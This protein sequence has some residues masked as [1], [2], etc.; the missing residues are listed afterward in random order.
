MKS[1]AGVSPNVRCVLFQ[2]PERR[3]TIKH[4]LFPLRSTA[5]LAHAAKLIRASAG[6]GELPAI[7]LLSKHGLQADTAPHTALLEALSREAGLVSYEIARMLLP[8]AVKSTLEMANELADQQREQ[9]IEVQGRLR[10]LPESFTDPSSKDRMTALEA[11]LIL[12]A[13]ENEFHCSHV[14]SKKIELFNPLRKVVCY[15]DRTREPS[16]I[17]II[18]APWTDLKKLCAIEGLDVPSAERW[19]HSSNLRS[20]PRHHHRGK[21]QIPY[22]YSIICK[23]EDS[24]KR[25]L[26]A[27]T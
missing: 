11:R 8:E 26:P 2:P 14:T 24:F 18:V 23:S 16:V 1:G 12:V 25:L 17:A 13:D 20:F 10:T 7:Q 27:L 15:I 4:F 9:V 21:N 3:L 19:Y 6:R 5:D 22:G